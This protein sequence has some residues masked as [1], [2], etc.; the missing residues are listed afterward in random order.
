MQPLVTKKHACVVLACW[1]GLAAQI[2]AQAGQPSHGDDILHRRAEVL[3]ALAKPPDD[4]VPALV[5]ALADDALLVRRTAIQGLVRL[6]ALE[7]AALDRAVTH[8]DPQIRRIAARHAWPDGLDRADFLRLATDTD[9]RVRATLPH[10]LAG[11][12]AGE[13][14]REVDGWPGLA[15]DGW[16]NAW[17]TVER[18]EDSSRLDTA[19]R[20]KGDSPSA[21]AHAWVRHTRRGGEEHADATLS[22]GYAGI[23]GLDMQ[24]PYV[25][26]M[27]IKLEDSEPDAAPGTKGTFWLFEATSRRWSPGSNLTW[28]IDVD[29]GRWRFFHGDGEGLWKDR[30]TSDMAAETGKWYDI[31]VRMYPDRQRWDATITGEQTSTRAS[32]LNDGEPLGY[33]IAEENLRPRRR[34]H[35]GARVDEPGDSLAWSVDK[36]LI[37]PAFEND[38]PAQ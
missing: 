20:E 6:S 17:S 14:D 22:R 28:R 8:E 16:D 2:C 38:A 27:R 9:R 26:R 19:L 5:Q 11:F 32:T 21:G 34:L 37:K 10:L 4:A 31:E 33:R 25:I 23:R 36:V 3:D 30:L 7:G 29:Q 12:E 24:A 18:S 13:T 15:G 35:V 1:A